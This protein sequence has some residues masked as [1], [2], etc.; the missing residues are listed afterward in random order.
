M[1]AEVKTLSHDTN[2]VGAATEFINASY[3]RLPIVNN[4]VLLGQVSRRDI[5]RAARKLSKP[6]P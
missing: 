2:I 3:R 4:G 1:T 5:L 6:R